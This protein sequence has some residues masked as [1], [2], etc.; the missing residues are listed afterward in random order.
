[1]GTELIQQPDAV[2]SVT[3]H[4]Q[5]F[6]QEFYSHG[7]AMGVRQLPRQH[8]RKPIA[9]HQFAHW[10]PGSG[11]RQQF[12]FFECQHKLCSSLSKVW[13][14]VK[15]SKRIHGVEYVEIQPCTKNPI[16]ATISVASMSRMNSR[17]GSQSRIFFPTN[18][19]KIMIDPSPR[20][21]TILSD[22]KIETR[23]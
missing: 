23:R 5:R 8:R 16:P 3:E 19:P 15:K 4:D 13:R 22:V 6:A 11:P 14:S 17:S 20:P 21:I 10:R 12:I 9:P 1:M 7:R 18:D 2:L